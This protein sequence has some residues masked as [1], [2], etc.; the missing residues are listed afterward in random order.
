MPGI[1]LKHGETYVSMTET[2]YDSEGVLQALIA[3]H[4]EVLADEHAGQGRLLLVRREAGVS[5]QADAG[6]RWSLDHLYVDSDGIPTLVEVKRSSDT[7]GRREVV[8]QMLDYAANAKISFS[9]ERMAAWL[10]ED[11]EARGTTAAQMLSDV[12]GIEDPDVFWAT[13]ATNLDAERFRLVFVSDVIPPELRQIIEFLNGQMAQT[14]VLA[15]EVKQYV[16][17]RAQHQT[18]VPRVI[19]NTET[20]KRT[21]RAQSSRRATDRTSLIA[22]LA[23]RDAGAADAAEALLDWGEQHPDLSIIWNRAGDIAFAYGKSLLRVWEEG[24][25]EVKVQTLRKLDSGWDDDERI[26]QLLQR[27]E[28]IDGVQFT[29]NRRQWP[30]TP[31]APLADPRKR[32]AFLGA[33][34]DVVRELD[35]ES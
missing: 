15:I 3:Q 31:L 9:P 1:Y 11:A 32:E 33:I 8:A 28:N 25:V 7:R 6:G 14:E 34:D 26:E 19:G 17:D 21:K 27:L 24:T 30:R 18:I 20:A 4:P 35:V 12:L 2:P 13:V 5:D 22:A 16:D 29:N 23:D 10:E